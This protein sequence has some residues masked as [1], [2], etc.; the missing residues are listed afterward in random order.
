MTHTLRSFNCNISKFRGKTSKF[1]EKKN[2]EVESTSKFFKKKNFEV[3][4]Y[5]EVFSESELQNFK[6]FEVG[7]KTVFFF[8][9]SNFIKKLRSSKT[10]FYMWKNV[11]I[12]CSLHTEICVSKMM[13]KIE[14]KRK[15]E[16]RKKKND[17]EQ[18][19][20][21]DRSVLCFRV[22]EVFYLYFGIHLCG[23]EGGLEGG[24]L[25]PLA[26]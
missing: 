14:M 23:R 6:Y 1:F 12:D 2:F 3:E 26:L 13:K 17:C 19:T 9:T 18:E 20:M 8:F 11:L 24:V 15:Q 21:R 10:S 5:F 16:T 25:V 22:F 4:K 7:E